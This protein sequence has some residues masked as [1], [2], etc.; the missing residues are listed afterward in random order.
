VGT[1]GRGL[2]RRDAAGTRWTQLTPQNSALPGREVRWL[3]ESPSGALWVA[4]SGAETELA[5]YR[6]GAF[7]ALPDTLL[8][9]ENPS[10]IH[11]EKA[12]V[13]WVGTTEAGLHRVDLRGTDA[14]DEATA[15]AYRRRDGLPDNTIYQVMRDEQG[16]FWISTPNG[17][18]TVRKA[19]LEAVARGGRD[20]VRAAV[21]TTRDGL[22]NVE[23]NGFGTPGAVATADGRLWFPNQAGAT[24]VDPAAVPAAPPPPRMHAESVSSGGRLVAEALDGSRP[25]DTAVRL[26]KDQ[27]TFRVEYTGIRTS[28]PH[29]LEF[30]YRLAG[31]QDDWVDA[32]NRRTAFFTEV[33]PG[34]YTFEVA[35]RT[36]TGPWSAPPARLGVTVAPYFYETWWFAALGV[37]ALGLAGY[38]GVQYRLHAFRRRQDELNDEVDTRTRELAAAKEE[39]ENARADAEDALETVE[40]QAQELREIDEMKSRFFA[41]VSHELRTPLSLMQGPIKEMLKIDRP[42]K[43]RETLRIVRRNARRLERLVEQLLDLARYDA[44]RIERAC[45][46]QP[47]GPFV[48]RVGQR[49]TPMAEAKEI[50]LSVQADGADAA[51]VFDPDHMETVV[52]NLI[53]NALTYVPRGGGVTVRAEVS[54]E[55]GRLVVADTGPGIPP[56]EQDALFDRFYR[57]ASQAQ[58]GGTGIGLSL[59]KALVTLHEGTIRV[60]SAPGEGSTFVVQWPRTLTV[61]EGA[62]E[63]SSPG[64]AQPLAPVPEEKRDEGAAGTGPSDRTTVLVV[65]DNADVRRYVR[66][67]LEPHYRV[68][69]AENGRDGLERTRTAL[70]DLVVTDVMMPEMDGVE[71][72]EALRRHPRTDTIPVLMLTARA[73]AA[74]QVEGLER[75]ADAYVTKPFEASVLTARIHGLIAIRQRLRERFRAGAWGAAAEDSESDAPTEADSFEERIRATIV[76]HLADPDFTVERLAEAVGRTRRTV[77]RRTKAAFGQT[78]SA[79]IRTARVERGAALLD[80]GAGTVSEVAYAV[81]FN[82]LSYFSRCFKEH[83]GVPPSVYRTD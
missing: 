52:A 64:G 5:R 49:F 24:V 13:L 73:E 51:L 9:A 77:T 1:L 6:D 39:A 60:E 10:F 31:L 18:V 38:G 25:A 12:G 67:L 4:L 34:E 61:D 23:G 63:R 46:R 20:R 37:L 42:E 15:V 82:S 76:E 29:A 3:H 43:E 80:D 81:G 75:G 19:D 7:E 71:M 2:F 68:L 55:A 74:D 17:I 58:R 26:A 47:W 28:R 36:R 14:L 8:P 32:G 21:Y 79:L 22:R 62:T 66:T 69:E 44:G 50:D 78:P 40:E 16:R 53:R 70:P 48:R 30:R 11:Q 27:R 56:D 59:T 35:G 45:Q 33:P 57:G 65:E 41:N 54:D 72:L 83:F